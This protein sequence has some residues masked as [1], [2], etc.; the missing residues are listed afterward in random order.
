MKKMWILLVVVVVAAQ[1][2]KSAVIASSPPKRSDVR[3]KFLIMM[4]FFLSEF[5]H[6]FPLHL[7]VS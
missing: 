5:F 3:D 2:D 1:A 4:D 7:I 6:I